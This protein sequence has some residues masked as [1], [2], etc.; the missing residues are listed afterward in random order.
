MILFLCGALFGF[1]VALVVFVYQS[2]RDH[3][4]CLKDIRKY[5]MANEYFKRA[6]NAF[7]EQDAEGFEFWRLRFKEE[8]AR[9]KQIK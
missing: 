9:I 4:K 7:M 2:I 1:T 3:K 5:D 6:Q 8:A